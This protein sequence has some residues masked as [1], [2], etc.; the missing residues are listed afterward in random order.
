MAPADYRDWTRAVT[1]VS[2]WSALEWWDPTYSGVERPESLHG[3]RVTVGYFE[4]LG[5]RPHLGRTFA[6]E[7]GQPGTNRKVV[8]SHAFWLRRFNASPAVLGQ[9]MRLE[10]APHEI[11]GVMTPT[12]IAPLPW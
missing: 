5:V 10:G 8:I 6:A 9:T 1:T 4:M 12:G 11:V 2:A 7:D 3:F